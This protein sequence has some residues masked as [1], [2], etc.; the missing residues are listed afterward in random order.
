MEGRV[1][2]TG[3]LRAYDVYSGVHA[4]GDIQ[5]ILWSGL[6]ALGALP[7]RVRDLLVQLQIV[8]SHDLARV[9]PFHQDLAAVAEL[10]SKRR[11]LEQSQDCS[12]EGSDIF[13]R[14]QES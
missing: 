8:L 3:V 9:I 12:T 2:D 13:G 1:H 7:Q 14:D 6:M 4:L 11:I 10:G 5:Q